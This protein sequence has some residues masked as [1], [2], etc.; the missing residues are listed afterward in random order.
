[1]HEIL[2]EYNEKLNLI[3]LRCPEGCRITTWN[4]GD[5]ILNY[6]SFSVAYCPVDADT[7]IYHCVS[8]EDDTKYLAEQLEKILLTK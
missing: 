4:E 5:D 7:S 6:S 8:V 2:K 1:M 3:V